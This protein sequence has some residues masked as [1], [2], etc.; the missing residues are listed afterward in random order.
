M[1]GNDARI[2][3][4]FTARTGGLVEDN[5]PNASSPVATGFDLILQ[6]EAGSI[7]GDSGANYTLTILAINDDTVLPEPR[8][9]PTGGPFHEEWS[10]D[11]GWKLSGNDYVKT[12]PDESVG[13]VRYRIAIPGGLVGAFHYNARLVSKNC[14]VVSFAQSNPFILV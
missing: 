2:V 14:Q 3:R 6:A 1:N 10:S 5:T 4:L 9:D 12:G 11:H 7:L 8:L 13:I